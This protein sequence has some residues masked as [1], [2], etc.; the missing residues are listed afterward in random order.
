MNKIFLFSFKK[1]KN[2]EFRGLPPECGWL[3]A[4]HACAVRRGMAR[5]Y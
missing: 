4:I 5:M 3:P 1:K 2:D